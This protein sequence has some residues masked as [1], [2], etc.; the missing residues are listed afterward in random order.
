MEINHI[1]ILL[2]QI[3]FTQGY[4]V[5]LQRAS[6]RFDQ[7]LTSV[8]PGY[9][10]CQLCMMPF[11]TPQE[12]SAHYTTAHTEPSSVG[13]GQYECTLCDRK[14]ARKRTLYEHIAKVHGS[15]EKHAC[16]KC[17]KSYGWRTNL[18]RHMKQCNGSN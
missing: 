14:Y 9:I 1:S 3:K 16:S 10:N 11:E 2:C 18:F 5:F 17:G 4:F 8:I 7:G 15:G 12:L 6:Y 13:K